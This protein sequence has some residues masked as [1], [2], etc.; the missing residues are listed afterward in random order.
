ML[1]CG[2][3]SLPLLSTVPLPGQSYQPI[4]RPWIRILYENI[5]CTCLQALAI[6]IK[7]KLWSC[8]IV[9]KNPL[10]PSSIISQVGMSFWKRFKESML[11]FIGTQQ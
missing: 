6:E 5:A 11:S 8:E 9:F 3:I 2:A 1:E 10:A 4:S 7:H